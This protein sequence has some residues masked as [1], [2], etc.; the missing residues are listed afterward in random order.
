[1]NIMYAVTSYDTNTERELNIAGWS[2]N[3][4]A[5]RKLESQMN[6]TAE[7]LFGDESA[8]PLVAYRTEAIRLYGC[9][10]EYQPYGDFDALTRNGLFFAI[11]PAGQGEHYHYLCEGA[12]VVHCMNILKGFDSYLS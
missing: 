5:A 10:H 11:V 7:L 8:A 4:P 3:E 9:A 1:M 6:D 12:D 2:A